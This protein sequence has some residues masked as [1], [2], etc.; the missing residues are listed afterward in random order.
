ML[1]SAPRKEQPDTGLV[2]FPSFSP[3]SGAGEG[4]RT[5]VTCLG[6]KSSTI[7]LHPPTGAALTCH[8]RRMR[9]MSGVDAAWIEPVDPRRAAMQRG[10]EPVAVEPPFPPRNDD[11]R[12]RIADEIGQAAAFAHEAVD[13]KD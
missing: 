7:E 5:L 11:R 10:I 13:A 6:S 12:H 1:Q 9:S 4:N 8:A 2:G 3:K